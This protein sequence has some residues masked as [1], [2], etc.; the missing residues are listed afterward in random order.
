LTGRGEKIKVKLPSKILRP[1]TKIIMARS[2]FLVK[3]EAKGQ[4]GTGTDFYRTTCSCI[5]RVAKFLDIDGKQ[6][7]PSLND[8]VERAGYTRAYVKPDGTDGEVTVSEGQKNYLA[9][10]KANART[11]FLTTGRKTSKGN[12]RKLSFTFPSNLSIAEIGDAL[13]DII[14]A[15][16]VNRTS[17]TGAADIDIFYCQGWR[18]LSYST[19]T[20][21]R[22]Y[23][24]YRRSRKSSRRS[25]IVGWNK[26]S[27]EKGNCGHFIIMIFRAVFDFCYAPP[28][29]F[30]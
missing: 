1:R 13:G 22:S 8:L 11:I 23:Y 4:T 17:A 9:Y 26:E 29:S 18:D 12:R 14:P 3:Y 25:D 21:S 24:R 28:Y 6:Y 16:K 30:G 20:R 19:A 7:V 15:A 5:P 10:G 2:S 27:Q